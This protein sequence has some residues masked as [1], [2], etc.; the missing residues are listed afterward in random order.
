MITLYNQP[1]FYTKLEIW[2]PRYSSQYTDWE[3]KVALLA[4]YKV[5]RATPILLIEFTKAKHLE[6][7]R[8]AISR[9]KAISFGIDNNGKIPCYVVPMSALNEWYT[10]EEVNELANQEVIYD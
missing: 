2:A 1:R 3:E 6:S 9:E 4:K 5:D 10:Q 8:F 7:Q